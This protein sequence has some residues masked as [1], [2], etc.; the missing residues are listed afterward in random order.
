M[1]EAPFPGCIAR[2][3][4]GRA[5]GPHTGPRPLPKSPGARAQC[6][7]NHSLAESCQAIVPKGVICLTSALGLF[8]KTY[9]YTSRVPRMDGDWPPR[10]T[11]DLAA[12][13]PPLQCRCGSAKE[14]C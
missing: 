9:R 8:M 3:R 2:W 1:I 4:V 12:D 14:R 6:D 10:G 5:F 11:A 13:D 7:A